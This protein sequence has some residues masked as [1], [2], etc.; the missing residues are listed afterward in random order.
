MTEVGH[1]DGI[2]DVNDCEGGEETYMDRWHLIDTMF[3]PP[4]P[5]RQFSVYKDDCFIL[6]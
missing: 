6:F 4:D 2:L 1:G 3:H 5:N